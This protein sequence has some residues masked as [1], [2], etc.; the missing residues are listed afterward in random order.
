LASVTAHGSPVNFAY[1]IPVA[2]RDV[3]YFDSAGSVKKSMLGNLSASFLKNCSGI[4][5]SEA[6][7]F[8]S[9]SG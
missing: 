2:I 8:A 1:R 5:N 7:S 3:W 6:N 9:A 4:I